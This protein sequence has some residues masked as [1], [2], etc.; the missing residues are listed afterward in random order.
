M[1][2]VDRAVFSEPEYLRA[3]LDAYCEAFQQGTRG[4]ALDLKLC[5]GLWASWLPKISMEV[6]LWHGEE[7]TNTPIAMA[8]YM[9]RAIPKT[10]ATFI[11]G[12]GHISLMHNHG[13]EIFE[14][15]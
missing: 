15:L 10:R 13:Q 7:D 2:A 6:Q 8:H 9:Q 11:P 3:V 4:P 1:P 14:A 12:E 5:A